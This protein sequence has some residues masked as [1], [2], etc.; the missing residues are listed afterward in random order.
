MHSYKSFGA[1]I[2][3][4]LISILFAGCAASGP[5]FKPM[6]IEATP[7]GKGVVYIYRQP[8][9]VGGAVYGTVTANHKPITKI[10]NGGYFPYVSDPG[11]VHFEVSTEAT[12]EADVMVE[13]GKEK[14]LKTTVGIG[15]FVGHLKFSEVSPEIGRQ[16]ITECKLLEP[17][18]P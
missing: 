17:I 4:I 10:R 9:L 13:A 5:A 1:T 7:L 11:P 16:E 18:Q 14:Y 8:G 2:W 15:L 6:P 12:N 3:G